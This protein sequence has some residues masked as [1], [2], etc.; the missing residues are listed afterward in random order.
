MNVSDIPKSFPVRKVGKSPWEVLI[1]TGNTWLQCAT[2]LDAR[3][4]A[5]GPVF[6]Y[7]SLEQTRSGPSFAAELEELA[8]T[9][10]KYRL[11]FG[12]RFFRRRAAQARRN[13]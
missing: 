7:E 9:L 8:G 3:T 4:I 5:R 13:G 6:E 10:E 1:A 2:E 11:G 12:S